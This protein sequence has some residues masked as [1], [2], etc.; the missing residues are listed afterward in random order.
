V[1]DKPSSWYAELYARDAL[2]G[3]HVIML[4]ADDASRCAAAGQVLEGSAALVIPGRGVQGQKDGAGGSAR[5]GRWRMAVSAPL[6][7]PAPLLLMVLALV[8]PLLA[9]D[10]DNGSTC[11]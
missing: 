6:L 11:C 4:G 2:T 9:A 5:D 8:G 7:M 10:A 3:G 1:S